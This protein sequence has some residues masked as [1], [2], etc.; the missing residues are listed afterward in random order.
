MDRAQP[1]VSAGESQCGS[2]KDAV[3]VFGTFAPFGAWRKLNRWDIAA[4]GEPERLHS[5]RFDARSSMRSGGPHSPVVSPFDLPV[6][7]R[8]HLRYRVEASRDS[9]RDYT[10]FFVDASGI[11]IYAE[12]LTVELWAPEGVAIAGET[13][14]SQGAEVGVLD[15]YI[16]P[17]TTRIGSALRPVGT[18]HTYARAGVP[19]AVPPRAQHYAVLSGEQP[20]LS[21]GTTPIA[22]SAAAS[23]P[24]GGVDTITLASDSIVLWEV[25]P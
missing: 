13:E 6:V 2:P 9:A 8:G 22:A 5:L 21:I 20:A 18:L 14:A 10:D 19:H 7:G 15:E 4:A 11:D 16:A 25:A 23:G 1:F 17:T 3:H 24:V 12:S